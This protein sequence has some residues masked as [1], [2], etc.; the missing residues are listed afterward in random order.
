MITKTLFLNYTTFSIIPGKAETAD[1]QPRGLRRVPEEM[2][3]KD[4]RQQPVRT[5]SRGREGA[6][7]PQPGQ[8]GLQVYTNRVA[9]YTVKTVLNIG[10]VFHYILHL[11]VEQKIKYTKYCFQHQ[12]ACQC[13]TFSLT[14]IF[15]LIQSH[16]EI[17]IMSFLLIFIFVIIMVIRYSFLFLNLATLAWSK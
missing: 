12:N 6:D 4:R 17:T 5:R 2:G 11:T 13:Q 14:F 10:T 15:L 16:K 1:I 7:P 8:Q 9:N 3:Q